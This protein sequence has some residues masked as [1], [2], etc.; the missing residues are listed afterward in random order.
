MDNK[1]RVMFVD[2]EPNVLTSIRRMLRSKSRE[3]DMAFAKSGTDALA[4]FADKPFDVI[5]SDIRMPGMDG[6]E[7]LQRIKIDYNNTIRI[8]LSGQVG[9]NEVVRSIRAVHQYISKPCSADELVKKI[10]GALKSKDIL[11]DMAM[12]ELVSEIETL[13]V[14]PHVFR[15]IE[16]EL[17]SA[18]PSI[19][20]IAE[21]ISM[22]VGLVAKII[23]LVNSPYFGL[24]SQIKSIFQA[25]TMLGIDTINA[26]IVG[27]HLFSM[28]DEQ[29]I[30]RFSLVMLWEHS[31]RVS[32]IAR[33]IAEY[34]GL[35]REKV[36]QVRMAGLLH[37]V[38]KLVLASSFAGEYQKVLDVVAKKKCPIYSAENE[39]FGTTHAQIGAYLMGL[40]G[41]C[42]EVVYGIG[43]HHSYERYDLS[44][45]M[46]VSIADMID[47]QCIIINKDYS[48]VVVNR[49][50]LDGGGVERLEEWIAHI[51]DN[52][53]GIVRF[54]SLDAEILG[55]LRE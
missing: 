10:D 7:L 1:V 55:M 46:L 27:T 4:L 23:K 35:D 51:A 48:R 19:K 52:W 25:I 16:E 2:D 44:V 5:V 40:W 29:A 12:Q 32:N 50:L 38:G 15:S 45:P 41:M 13:P 30:P 20:K 33:M 26:L 54:N 36:I 21:L 47:H 18:E 11:S 14:I 53:D 8:A 6:A 17:S 43:Y 28:Y 22:D 37:D 31:F 39:I 24:P 49:N 42:G 34:E 3:W 9:L